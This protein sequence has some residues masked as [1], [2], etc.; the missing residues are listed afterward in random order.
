MPDVG[1][2]DLMKPETFEDATT[3]A[4][5]AAALKALFIAQLVMFL[6]VQFCA[7]CGGWLGFFV[8]N[9][10]HRRLKDDNFQRA[11]NLS[12]EPTLTPHT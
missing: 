2:A 11:E 9:I 5:N 12:D 7:V 8:K 1:T 6:P 4:D 10:E 3:F